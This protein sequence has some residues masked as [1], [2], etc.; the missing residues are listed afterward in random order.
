MGGL[1]KG[2]DLDGMGF[3]GIGSLRKGDVVFGSRSGFFEEVLCFG[4]FL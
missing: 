2:R 1:R 3:V 4:R